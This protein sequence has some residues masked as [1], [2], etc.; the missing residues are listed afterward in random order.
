MDIELDLLKQLGYEYNE[1]LDPQLVP[2]KDIDED[3]NWFN[4]VFKKKQ[5]EEE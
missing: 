5:C 1:C 3:G 2:E 4:K